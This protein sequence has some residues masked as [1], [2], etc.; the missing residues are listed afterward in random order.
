MDGRDDS[1]AGK[2]LRQC[3]IYFY[4]YLYLYL[5]FEQASRDHLQG[6]AGKFSRHCAM[7][8]RALPMHL[9]IKFTALLHHTM[10]SSE[11]QLKK[12]DSVDSGIRRKL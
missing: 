8:A 1:E 5:H 12:L 10:Q 11:M 6:E 9:I 2:Y 7:T 4:F 3:A